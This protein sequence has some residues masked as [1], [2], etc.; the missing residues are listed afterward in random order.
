MTHLQI[1]QSLEEYK[2]QRINLPLPHAVKLIIE[3]YV[4]LGDVIKYMQFYIIDGKTGSYVDSIANNIK[5]L[6]NGIEQEYV[7]NDNLYTL[8]NITNQDY[9][10]TN[11]FEITI[12]SDNYK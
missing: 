2:R 3:D 8:F 5:I 12:L 4:I 9:N 10:F 1:M 6:I 7:V 11:T